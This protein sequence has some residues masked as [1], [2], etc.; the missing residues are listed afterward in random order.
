MVALVLVYISRESLPSF[1]EV[2]SVLLQELGQE[3][4]TTTAIL[5]NTTLL[6][7][8]QALLPF[9]SRREGVVLR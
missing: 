8:P 9:T 4:C 7:A 1:K 6:I 3:V 5:G 2:K